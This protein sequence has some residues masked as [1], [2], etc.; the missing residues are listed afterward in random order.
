MRYVWFGGLKALCRSRRV[1]LWIMI[2][3]FILSSF[4]MTYE[5]FGALSRY[6]SK[7]RYD[8]RLREVWIE[9]SAPQDPDRVWQTVAAF[10]REES[11]EYAVVCNPAAMPY[12]RPYDT[13]MLQSEERFTEQT[14]PVISMIHIYQNDRQVPA[15]IPR[16]NSGRLVPSDLAGD[17][18][19]LPAQL[20]NYAAD[21]GQ[22]VTV[23]S[24][25]YDCM[26]VFDS[27]G[28]RFGSTV[29][30]GQEKF[31][32]EE[33]VGGVFLCFYPKPDAA[34]SGKIGR[35]LQAIDPDG[36]VTLPQPIDWNLVFYVLNTFR[37]S[38]LLPTLVFLSLLLVIIGLMEAER[39][40]LNI[41]RLCGIRGRSL[42]IYIFAQ[43]LFPCLLGCSVGVGLCYLPVVAIVQGY[44]Q[45]RTEPL[46]AVAIFIVFILFCLLTSLAAFIKIRRGTVVSRMA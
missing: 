41:F 36:R 43:L 4:Y 31:C 29:M 30:V 13:D 45:F 25:S 5:M 26:Q 46:D 15:Y 11:F 44:G 20:Q 19:Y 7:S 3:G 28:M 38:L 34:L 27:N 39:E 22:T 8:E 2:V 33:Q 17:Q 10:T 24:K 1:L 6:R 35:A 32:R 40:R 23:G 16:S 37:S 12:C 18:A 14:L 21:V 42:F 9:F